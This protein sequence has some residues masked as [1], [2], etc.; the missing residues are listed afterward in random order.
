MLRTVVV[1]STAPMPKPTPTAARCGA[2]SPTGSVPWPRSVAR[3]TSALPVGRSYA[4]RPSA[5][6]RPI[7][8]RPSASPT[9]C[10]QMIATRGLRQVQVDRASTCAVR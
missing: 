2:P 3:A 6:G 9:A 5:I 10:Q 7:A 8:E 1:S 4:A